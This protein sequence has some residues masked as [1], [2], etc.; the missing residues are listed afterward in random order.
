MAKV[1]MEGDVADNIRPIAD[2]DKMDGSTDQQ[3]AAA[4]E[5]LRSL[6]LGADYENAIRQARDADETRR[7][8]TVL[9]EAI[10]LRSQ[11]DKGVQNALAPAIDDVLDTSIRRDPVKLARVISPIIGPSIRAAVRTAL[12]DMVESLNRILERSFSPQSWWWR[13]QAWRAGIPFGQFILLRTLQFRVEQVLLIHRDTGILLQAETAPGVELREPQLVSAM[14]TAI[15]DFVSTSFKSAQDSA[16]IKRIRFGDRLLLVDAGPRAVIAALVL[17]DPPPSLSAQ[18]STTLE[19]FHRI[20]A[21]PLASFNGDRTPFQQAE[22]LLQDCLCEQM[23]AQ[24]A[25]SKPWLALTLIAVL[26]LGLMG[27]GGYQ[28]HLEQQRNQVLQ[29]LQTSPTHVVLDSAGDGR[30]L[31]VRLLSQFG[32]PPPRE[33][34][35]LAQQLGIDLQLQTAPV[36][37][38]AEDLLLPYLERRYRL[39]PEVSLRLQDGVLQIG[40]ALSAQQM[41]QIRADGWVQQLAGTLDVT[42]VRLLPPPDQ[43]ALDWQRWQD[44]VDSIQQQRFY[45]AEDAA[46]LDEQEAA[47]AARVLVQLRDLLALANTLDQQHLQI[48]VHGYANST[49][50]DARNARLSR[51]RAEQ[52]RHFFVA[53]GINPMLVT[54]MGVGSLG[55]SQLTPP[56]KRFVALQVIYAQPSDTALNKTE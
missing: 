49:G 53:N 38:N 55:E 54:A 31:R 36:A 51:D 20:F 18:L 4:V 41:T 5:R 37:M 25:S 15:K 9:A 39:G 19:Q 11:Q 16:E 33:A 22:P 7:V 24:N 50:T 43:R 3:S 30:Q 46:L 40:G 42:R 8:A 48:L 35:A 27:W 17:G 34:L 56:Q 13:V 21:E 23:R 1:V 28:W 14:L 10:H 6:I 29:Q 2:A 32:A 52:L 47:K 45:F 26:L 12:A 44:L